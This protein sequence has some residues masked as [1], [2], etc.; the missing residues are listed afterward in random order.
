MRQNDL[1]HNLQTLVEAKAINLEVSLA[2]L[3]KGG[4]LAG[5]EP[6]DIFCG[7]GWVFRRRG[8]IG[9]QLDVDAIRSIVREQLGAL[10]GG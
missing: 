5:E 1:E 2:T 7:N 10:K 8:P 4:A 3:V 9:S 6:W